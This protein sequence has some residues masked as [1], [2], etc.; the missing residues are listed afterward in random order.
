MEQKVK[1]TTC[2]VVAVY[3]SARFQTEQFADENVT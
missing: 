2:T 1:K 3:E